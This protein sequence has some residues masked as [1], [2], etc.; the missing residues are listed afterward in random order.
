MR[1]EYEQNPKKPHPVSI[2]RKSESGLE[3]QEHEPH[4]LGP[5]GK[6]HDRYHH[7]HVRC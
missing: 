4:K 7:Q 6:G 3:T 1:D 2:G 5:D